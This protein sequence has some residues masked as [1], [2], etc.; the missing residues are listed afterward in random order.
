MNN[1]KENQTDLESLRND[2]VIKQ[3]KGL[4]FICASVVIWLLILIVVAL[5]LEQEKENIFVFCCSC[6]LLPI[7]WLIGKVLKVDIFDKSNPLGNVGFLFTCNQ[8][9][10]LLIVMWVFR[11]VPDKMVMVYAMVFGAHLLP[12][13][14]LYKSLSYRSFAIAIPLISLI[15]GCIFP[16][17]SVAVTML[18]IEVIFVISLLVEIRRFMKK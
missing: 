5:D 4:P 18:I 1:V 11:A 6:P 12:Y 17:F 10:Y 8:F 3:K 13:S 7:S 15:V 14:W 16:A 2:I 9:L